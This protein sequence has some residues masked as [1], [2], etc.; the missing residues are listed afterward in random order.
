MSTAI[1]AKNDRAPKSKKT[2]ETQCLLSLAP[3]GFVVHG[4]SKV[5]TVFD[6]V[7]SMRRCSPLEL[8]SGARLE[9]NY[10]GW[11]RSLRALL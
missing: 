10:G 2:E 1:S 11:V 7:A 9:T 5:C 6:I 3:D 8:P 4:R